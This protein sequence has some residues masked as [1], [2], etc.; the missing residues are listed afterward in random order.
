MADLG[1]N[2]FD[3][4]GENDL[5]VVQYICRLLFTTYYLINIEALY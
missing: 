2:G 4:L 3:G 1:I 5:E